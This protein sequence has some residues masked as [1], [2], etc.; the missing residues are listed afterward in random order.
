MNVILQD[1]ILID[2]YYNINNSSAFSTVQR[3]HDNLKEKGI[4]IKKDI[5]EEWLQRQNT[6]T[7]HRDRKTKFRRPIYIQSDKGR[8][9]DNRI[10]K[11][12][13]KKMGIQYKTT[14][15][16]VTKAAIC[17]RFIRTIKSIIY[18]YFTY[19]DTS[20]YV[21]VIESILCVYNSR[22][23]STIGMSPNDVNE[24]NVLNV[25]K[26]MNKHKTERSFEQKAKY[27]VGDFVRVA[28]PKKVFEK[29][30]KPKW[31]TEIFTVEKC[32]NR[33]PT[34]FRLKDC[35]GEC[36]NGNF[37]AEEIQKVSI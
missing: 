4:N 21:D 34:I 28:N 29:G 22:K 6:Y 10:V 37:Y 11:E 15:D 20:S 19:F 23:H 5:I 32:I 27:K 33:S 9:F 7:L 31:S 1:E 25:W 3:L 2:T 26:F 16:P 8:E 12:Y 14:K 30:Y 18:K 35:D 13:F 17:E 24:K 36:I